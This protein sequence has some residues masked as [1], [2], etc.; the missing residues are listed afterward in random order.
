MP[1]LLL[2]L[3]LA[4]ATL[5][6]CAADTGQTALIGV[7]LVDLESG[8]VR[9]DQTVIFAGDSIERVGPRAELRVPRG[10]SRVEAGGAWLIPG[11]WDMHTHVSMAGRGSLVGLLAHGVTAIRDMGGSP[12]VPAWRD[13]IAAG[14]LEGPRISTPV[15][16]VE[17][18]RWLSA[19]LELTRKLDTPSLVESLERRLAVATAEDAERAVDSLVALSADFLKIRNY[20]PREAYFALVRAAKRHGLRVEGHA[21]SIGFLKDASDSGFASIEHPVLASRNGT[22]MEGFS[23][24]D[25]EA[26]RE[27]FAALARNGTAFDPTLVSGAARLIPDSTLERAIA[28]SL[29]ESEPELRHVPPE[30]RDEWRTQLALRRGDPSQGIDW[31]AIHDS[32]LRMTGAMA[33]AG[34]SIVAGTDL[35]IPPLVPGASLADE[36]EL[37]VRDAG[38]TPVE[39]L[40]AATTN[41]ARL[42][43]VGERSGV[44]AP[45]RLADLVL[46]E[47]DPLADVGAV[48]RVRMVIAAGRVY[49]RAA[50]DQLLELA[51]R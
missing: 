44:I 28:D 48:R 47:A 34:I 7:S 30:L 43:G 33:A 12:V 19:V 38:L 9:P 45:G 3:S 37:L 23:S 26:R 11:L 6:G 51:G 14:L 32:S 4:L 25:P 27:L 16:I 1:R 5:P 15:T 42:A 35:A 46:L 20:P 40:R 21:P 17:S 36:L 8:T 50:L 2:L 41:A 39:A 24:L 29:G 49:D 31:A 10:A 18:E 22:L 13:S